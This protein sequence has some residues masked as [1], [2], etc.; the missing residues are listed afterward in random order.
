M[1][2]PQRIVRRARRH[3][4]ELPA[5]WQGEL[6]ALWHEA[7]SAAAERLARAGAAVGNPIV[8]ENRRRG[9]RPSAWDVRGS[10]DPS[11]EGFATDLSVAAGACVSFKIAT[12]AAAYAVEIFRLG[13]YG[14]RG[15]R[16][17]ADIPA[18][19]ITAHR[20]PPGVTDP[21][22]GLLDCGNWAVSASWDV[23]ADAVSGVYIAKLTRGDTGGASH[24]PFVVR[25]DTGPAD[26]LFQTSDTTWQAYNRYGGNSL[27]TEPRARKLSYNRPFITRGD[28]SG[29]SF[30]FSAEYAALRFLERNGYH[31]A[32]ATGI[33]TDR[34]G[35]DALRRHRVFLSV[36]HDEYW[37]ARQRENVQAARDAGVHLMFLSGNEMY[38]RIRFEPS[39]DGMATPYR[40]LVCYKDT[41]DNQVADPSGELT[42]TW[43]DPRLAGG[44]GLPE[45][46]LTGTMTMANDADFPLRVT[47]A[48]GKLRL[49]RAT[50]LASMQSRSASL[51]RHIVGYESDEDIDNGFRPPGLIRLSTTTG[52][53]PQ[54]MFHFGAEAVASDTE[55]HVT[56]YRAASG[57]LV[58]SA[59]TVQWA[60]GLDRH[61]DGIR[62]AAD[63]RI[64]QATVNM[65]ADMDVQ[66]AALMPGLT[67]A[68]ASADSAPPVS[69]IT[70]P[71]PDEK[72]ANGTVITVR[73]TSADAGGGLVAGVEVSIDGGASW[74]PAEG[75][76]SW[77]YSGVIHG[78]GPVMILSRATDDSANTQT[79]PSRVEVVVTGPCTLFGL[80]DPA[81][82]DSGEAAPAELGVRFRP[83]LD[84]YVTG[85]RFYK[86]AANTG[87][88]TGTLWSA[89]GHRLAA[90]TFVAET[91]S[92]WQT[93]EF[94]AAVPV[95]AGQTYV[96]SYFAPHGHYCAEPD[97]FYYRDYPAW[98]LVAE[99][100]SAGRAT[101]NGVRAAGACFPAGAADGT[102]YYV[103]VVFSS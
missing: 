17:V 34:R 89:D 78:A 67:R 31:V 56:L 51:A 90:G 93:L 58:F 46:A 9:T 11:I 8:R 53:S 7:V 64:Q 77:S 101:G 42:A 73:G 27:Y 6:P 43:R 91:P 66:P 40:T 94:P 2:L 69:V 83:E 92:G 50:G 39:S 35:P 15:A 62:R 13:Y 103:D 57:S 75:A 32:Y 98:P 14:G 85:V 102:N 24:V 4:R 29:R 96:A 99:A 10:G 48:E 71:A 74:H 76:S 45:N 19:R 3:I 59:G 79:P 16:K 25:D 95:K 87:R 12:D 54:H 52:P 30:L 63:R 1:S 88:H 97:F 84:G 33:D 38:W 49:W 80:A 61:H 65:L 86:T 26:I 21:D 18:H 55:H 70:A 68:A 47:A 60:W 28:V 100:T 5:L 37:S 72:I 36:G 20:Q 82:P 81:A 22:T 41:L 23:P 44:P